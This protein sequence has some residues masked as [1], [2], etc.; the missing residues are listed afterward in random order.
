MRSLGG[1]LTLATADGW[2]AMAQVARIRLVPAEAAALA[3]AGLMAAQ[4]HD[5]AAIVEALELPSGVGAVSPQTEFF[6]E[7]RA[8]R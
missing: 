8:R 6:R 1:A 5:V 4:P 7:W 3:W 2:A